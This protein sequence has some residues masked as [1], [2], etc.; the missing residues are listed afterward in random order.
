MER[1][2]RRGERRE[3]N[4]EF[5]GGAERMHNIASLIAFGGVKGDLYTVFSDPESAAS[6]KWG[7]PWGPWLGKTQAMRDTLWERILRLLPPEVLV[8]PARLETLVEQA[9]EYQMDKCHFHNAPAKP[10]TLYKT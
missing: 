10:L 8:P 1:R 3:L 6:K 9:L 7:S 5:L 2:R 4:K